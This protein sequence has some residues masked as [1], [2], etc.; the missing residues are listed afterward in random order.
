MILRSLLFIASILVLAS[1]FLV[2]K[3]YISQKDLLK[4]ASNGEF[5]LSVL[6]AEKINFLYPNL[7]LNSVPTLTYLSRYYSNINNF[8][9]AIDQLNRSLDQNPYNPYTKYLLSRNYVLL[10]DFTTAEKLLEKLFNDFPN[11]EASSALYISV[12]AE[13]ENI[14][15]LIEI[16]NAMLNLESKNI[17]NYYLSALNMTAIT[18]QDKLYYSKALEYYYKNF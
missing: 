9:F 10:N 13:T 17:W 5:K 12:L 4:D 6:E 2:L 8:E 16:Y 7:T 1:N 15:K 14:P 3:S 18:K 11:L